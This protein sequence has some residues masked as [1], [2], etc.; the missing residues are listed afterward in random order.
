MRERQEKRNAYMT[1]GLICMILLAF[2]VMDLLREDRLFSET[3]NR[4]LASKPEFSWES[5]FDGSFSQKYESYVTDQFVGRDKWIRLK[6]GADILMQKREINGVYLG[7]D[8]YLIEQHLPEDY[9]QELADKRLALLEK[10]V[11]RWDAKVMLVPTADNI[12]ID[13]LPS[14]AELY[15]QRALL[16][17]VADRLGGEHYVDVYRALWERQEEDIYYRTDHHWT[18]R[19]AYYGYIAWADAM[20]EAVDG[21]SAEDAVTVSE[22][23]LGTLHSKL[24]VTVRPDSIQYFPATEENPV[25]L[26][27]DMQKSSDSFYEE[28]Y[29]DTKNQY[30]YFLDD[31][32]AFIEIDTG[33]EN[34]R[35]LFVIKD[36]YANCMIPLL[37]RHYEKVYVAD[38]RYMNGR[39]FPFMES[40][41]PEGGMDVLVL[42]NCV[43]FLEEFQ[44]Y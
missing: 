8:E 9:P 36:S 37:A 6:T 17:T 4:I 40:W 25:E 18:T 31:N 20:G 30:G 32:H 33:N 5:L 24:N 34:G 14:Y 23:F 38:L 42:Y 44:Y 26:T 16:E 29:L 7:K 19:G 28:S 3:E 35:T 12:L 22:D 13:K 15:D 21:L 41:E 1:V 43:H 10:L 11:D 2:T 39:L 27:Y